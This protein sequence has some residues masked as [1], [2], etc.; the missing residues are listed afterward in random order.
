MDTQ[1]VELINGLA[2]LG[3]FTVLVAVW[4]ICC[5]IESR[6]EK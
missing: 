2:C 1:T 4:L 6:K 3:S 5:A